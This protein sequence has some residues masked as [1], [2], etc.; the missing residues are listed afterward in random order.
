M[1]VQFTVGNY[2]SIKDPVTLSLVSGSNNN[3]HV[4]KTRNIR[5]V[6]SAVVYGANASGKSNLLR[7]MAFMRSLVLN[8]SKVVQSTDEL[9][10]DPFRLSTDTENAAGMFEIVFITNDTRYR[11]GF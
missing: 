6:P 1:V 11:Y 2:R 9:P 7:A 3:K 5:L 4:F 8:E 10:Y